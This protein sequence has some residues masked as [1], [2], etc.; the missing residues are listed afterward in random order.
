MAVKC[1]VIPDIVTFG[2]VADVQLTTLPENCHV[3]FTCTSAP[4]GSTAVHSGAPH[5]SSPVDPEGEYRVVTAH[6][7]PSAAGCLPGSRGMGSPA[8]P[9]LTT[10]ATS[11]SMKNNTSN[12]TSGVDDCTFKIS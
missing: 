8:D 2:A 11:V 12:L 4:A 10:A 9:A 1:V 3:H 7:L 5:S 6:L